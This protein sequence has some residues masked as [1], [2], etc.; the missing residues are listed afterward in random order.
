[1]TL[2]VGLSGPDT[3]AVF[4]IRLSRVDIGGYGGSSP[5]GTTVVGHLIS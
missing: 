5:R 2:P 1:M 3:I 4:A